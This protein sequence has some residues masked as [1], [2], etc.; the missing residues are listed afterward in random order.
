MIPQRRQGA[1][2]LPFG[3][4]SVTL[5]RMS[6]AQIRTS[7]AAEL[8]AGDRI[9]GRFLVRRTHLGVGRTGRPWLQLWLGDR[10]GVVDGR[11]WDDAEA[12]ARG[13]KEGDVVD[14]EGVGVLHLDK[15]QL[16]ILGWQPVAAD[17]ALVESLLPQSGM[18]AAQREAALRGELGLLRN[19]W[20]LRLSESM[21]ADREWL[22]AFLRAPAAKAVHHAWLGGLA[23]HTVSMMKLCRS[24]AAH[25][26]DLGVTPLDVDLCVAGAFLHDIGKVEELSAEGAFEYT[27]AGRL[28][29]HIVL[30]LDRLD[31]AIGAV[32]GFPA[33]LRQHLRHLVLSHH[34]EYEFGSPRRPKTIEAQI[35]HFVDNLDAR[36]EMFRFA[37]AAQSDGDWSAYE[38]V[39]GRNVWRRPLG[40]AA[41]GE[42]GDGEAAQ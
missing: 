23:E 6:D 9:R 18:S 14:V 26:R 24:V 39:L 32:S 38:S 3:E 12:A 16:K 17:P 28:I 34:G 36:V 37:I 29:G 10:T 41:A 22:Q 42:G 19:P 20:L 5:A 40:A 4:G 1:R 13:I 7:T 30:G 27:D 8:R 25:Y 2:G 33:E 15:T 21:L 35:L 11:V 31:A